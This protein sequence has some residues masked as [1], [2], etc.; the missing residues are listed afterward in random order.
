[1]STD[2]GVH[3]TY[4]TRRPTFCDDGT[5]RLKFTRGRQWYRIVLRTPHHEKRERKKPMENI[6]I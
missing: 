5:T 3:P 4:M 2:P 1:M 6:R